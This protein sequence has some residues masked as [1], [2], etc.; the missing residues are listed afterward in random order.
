MTGILQELHFD[1]FTFV[2]YQTSRSEM[3]DHI[4]SRSWSCFGIKF[5]LT[6]DLRE[7]GGG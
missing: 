3:T 5:R 1:A 4:S 2:V 6:P 7:E